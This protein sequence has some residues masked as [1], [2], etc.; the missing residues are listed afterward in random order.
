MLL[1]PAEN[2]RN[3]YRTSYCR[4]YADQYSVR[5]CPDINIDLSHISSYLDYSNSHFNLFHYFDQHF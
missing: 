2:N 3:R 4:S 5:H 1:L